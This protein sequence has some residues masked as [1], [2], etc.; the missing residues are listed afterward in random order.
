M[1]LLYDHPIFREH[2]PGE[3]HPERAARLEAI[4]RALEESPL[5]GL[6]RCLPEQATRAQLERVHSPAY[7]SKLLGLRGRRAELDPETFT[8]ASTIDAALHAAG[9]AV[10]AVDAVIA[11]PERRAFALTRPPGHHAEHEQ[12]LGFCF[13]NNV[14]VAACH[15]LEAHGLERVMILDWDVHHGNG[16][17]HTF[18]ERADVLCVDLHQ[19][20]LWPEQSGLLSEVGQGAGEGY[21]VNIPMHAGQGDAAYLD[22]FTRII[23]PIARSYAPQLILVSAGFDAHARD[24]LAQMQV[25]A[26]GYAAMTQRVMALAEALCGGRAIFLLEGG[27]DL[28]GVSQGV[29]ACMDVLCGQRDRWAPPVGSPVASVAAARAHHQRWWPSLG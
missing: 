29:R 20:D 19:E 12:A 27:Y 26:A 9:A 11:G 25:S 28:E 21:M 1:T 22:A 10:A 6:A 16:A 14:A 3:G 17:Q 5:P 2:N 13:F 4:M 7:V 18:W 15:A 23:E 24:P 8:S